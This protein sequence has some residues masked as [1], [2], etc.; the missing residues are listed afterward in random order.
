MPYHVEL[1]YFRK[2]GKYYSSGTYESNKQHIFQIWDEVEAMAKH[3][4]LTCRWT[5]GFILVN[6]PD[7]P[8]DHPRLVRCQ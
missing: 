1:T 7:H 2:T 5:D 4:D 6:V 8:D 3:P